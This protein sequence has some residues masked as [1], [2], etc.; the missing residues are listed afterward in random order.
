MI[1]FVGVVMA[2][3]DVVGWHPLVSGGMMLAFGVAYGALIGLIIDV[4]EIQPFIVTLAGSFP[5]C[6]AV[7]S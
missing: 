1:G 3:L 6:A 4:C 7:A 2:N 5:C